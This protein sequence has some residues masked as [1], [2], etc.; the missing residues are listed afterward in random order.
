M[1]SIIENIGTPFDLSET[2]EG[3][4]E[5]MGA[6]IV[7]LSPRLGYDAAVRLPAAC[8]AHEPDAVVSCDHAILHRS[9]ADLISAQDWILSWAGRI[10]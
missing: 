2:L 7:R 10:R 9:F 1:P 5:G 3:L 6:R 8:A 4:P